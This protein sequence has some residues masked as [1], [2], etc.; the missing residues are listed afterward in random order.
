MIKHSQAEEKEALTEHWFFR[1]LIA[2]VVLLVIFFVGSRSL[3]N[4]VDGV[5]EYKAQLMTDR[6]AKS[7]SHIHQEWNRNGKPQKLR[8]DYYESKG[9]AKDVWVWLS[10]DGWPL[11][12][13][14]QD[15]TLNCKKLWMYFAETNTNRE[16]LVS[17]SVNSDKRFCVYAWQNQEGKNK[18]FKYDSLK[19]L[20]EHIAK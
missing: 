18:R 12:V 19:G 3:T 8:L 17:I 13:D 16:E 15:A 6:F 2:G 14:E 7:I 10:E 11:T 9:N 1:V 5:G 20:L 4:V